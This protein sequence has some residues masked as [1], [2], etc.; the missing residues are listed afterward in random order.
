MFLSW[1]LEQKCVVEVES[2]EG[3]LKGTSLNK[4]TFQVTEARPEVPNSPKQ[5]VIW[6]RTGDVKWTDRSEKISSNHM[7]F[8][9]NRLS[10]W[11]VDG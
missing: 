5:Y 1:D 11:L 10:I 2:R 9:N 7:L 8:D 3:M 6:V 4:E